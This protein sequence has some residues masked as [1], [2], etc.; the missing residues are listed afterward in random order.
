MHFFGPT[1][2]EMM[3]AKAGNKNLP[4]NASRVNTHKKRQAKEKAA[5]DAKVKSAR[6]AARKNRRRR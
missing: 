2:D 6:D 4:A 3:A 1:P 5:A